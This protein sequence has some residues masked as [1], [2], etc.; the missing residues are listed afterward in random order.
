M[1]LDLFVFY[2]SGI[3]PIRIISLGCLEPDL[4]KSLV[5]KWLTWKCDFKKQAESGSWGQSVKGYSIQGCFVQLTTASGAW[6]S[7]TQN[8]WDALR[9]VPGYCS[10][11]EG[12]S[13]AFFHQLFSSLSSFPQLG[14]HIAHEVALTSKF[15][16]CKCQVGLSRWPHFCVRLAWEKNWGEVLSICTCKE[17]ADVCTKLTHQE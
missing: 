3:F 13:E 5:Y 6:S 9:N 2:V 8:L 11:G 4:R 1:L 10:P 16:K 12:K 7:I 17:L 15:P 14:Q